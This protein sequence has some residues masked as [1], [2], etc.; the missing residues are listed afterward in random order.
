MLAMQISNAIYITTDNQGLIKEL[1]SMLTFDNPEYHKKRALGLPLYNIPSRYKLYQLL[2][3]NKIM[4][5]RGT[6]KL[7]RELAIKYSEDLKVRD[8]RVNGDELDIE[9]KDGVKPYWYQQDAIDAILEH[10]Q[11]L[12]VAPCSAG[13][14]VLAIALI[15][16]LRVKAFVIVHTKDLMYQWFDR[17]DQ[18]LVGDYK[19]GKIGDGIKKMGDVTISTVQSFIR[20][21]P[22]VIERYQKE[23]GVVILDESHHCGANSYVTLMKTIKAKYILGL[24]ATP[25]RKDKKDFLIN[26]Y[27][28]GVAHT[29]SY[30]ALQM[31]GKSVSCKVNIVKTNRFYDFEKM[32]QDY[33]KLY[34]VIA[35]DKARNNTIVDKIMKDVKEFKRPLILTDRVYQAKFL[36]SLLKRQNLEVGLIT[37]QTPTTMRERAK[38]RI[39]KELD[40]VLIANKLIASEGLDLSVIDSVH[41]CFPTFNQSLLQQMIGRGRRVH[42]GKDYCRVWY[43]KDHVYHN[44]LD[45]QLVLVQKEFGPNK[46]NYLKTLKWFRS[47]DFECIELDH[48]DDLN[49]L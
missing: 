27:L 35:R 38:T 34:T 48:D 10:Q 36:Y 31:S 23:C 26:S 33:T 5:P 12:I 21:K 6:G 8:E 17:L 28:G 13:K 45:D 40:D 15:A 19:I 47:M 41:I 30:D 16:K 22:N 2:D 49:A 1:K 14:T 42:D 24:T 39:M 37:G 32:N 43:Y 11:G 4:I 7:T 44:E 3:V 46:F 25:K 18:F 20:L 9:L 29:I